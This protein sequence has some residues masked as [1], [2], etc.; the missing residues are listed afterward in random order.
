MPYDDRS[1]LMERLWQVMPKELKEPPKPHSYAELQFKVHPIRISAEV[2]TNFLGGELPA[3]QEEM[4]A[5]LWTFGEILSG[6]ME[7]RLHEIMKI[8]RELDNL[9]PAVPIVVKSKESKDEQT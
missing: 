8:A 7:K 1:P 6:D 9:R 3:N 4:R 5:V 2:F